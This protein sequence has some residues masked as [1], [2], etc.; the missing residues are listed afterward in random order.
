MRIH[1]FLICILPLAFAATQ[2]PA[3]VRAVP[4]RQQ[5]YLTAG[6]STYV[7]GVD[8]KKMVESLYWGPAL[9]QNTLL[10]TAKSARERAS[11]DNQ[12]NTTPLEYP[13]WGAGLDLEPALKV[14]S[15]N[16]DRTLVLQYDSANVGSDH[17]E[18]ILKDTAQP[19]R[20]HLHYQVFAEG[21]LARWSTIENI[22]NR[23]VHIEQAASA[24]FNLP[25]N[26]DYTLSQLTGMWGGEFQLQTEPLRFGAQQLESRR[27]STGHQANPWFSIGREGKTTETSGPVWFGELG[28]SGSWRVDV[29]RTSL[30]LVRITTGY[31][32]FDFGYTLAP[33]KSLDTPHVYAGYT[34]GGNGEAS[35]VLH[36]FQLAHILPKGPDAKPRPIIFNS[37]E[38]TEFH[39]SEAGQIALAE[40]AAKIGVERFVMDDGW[41]G[42]RKD[43]HAGLGDWYVNKE[44]FPNGL[45]PL[46]DRV[47]A[48]NMS[49][50]LWVEPEMVNP[51][52]DLYRKHPDW[53]MHFPDRQRTEQRNQLLLNLA[54]PEVKA[55]VFGWLDKLVTENDIAFLKWD[56]NRNW[57]EPGWGDVPQG[58][59][60]KQIYVA[61]VQNLYDIFDKLRA[62][63]PLLEI[64]SCSGGGGRVDLGILRYTDEVW[65]SDNTDAFDRL[66]IQDGFTRAYTPQAMVA[67]VTDVPNSLNR[68]SVPLEYRF[69]VAM[70][71]ALGIGNDLNKFTDA[72][73]ALATKLTTLY[74]DVRTTV[75]HGNLYRLQ[76]P[77][78][79]ATQVQYV[80]RD[81]AQSVVFAYLHSERLGLVQPRV[82][83]EGLDANSTYKLQPLDGSKFHGESTATGAQL[84]GSGLDLRL[85]GDFDSTAAVLTRVIP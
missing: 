53:A 82:P 18:L 21:V 54:K 73:M 52:S 57:S 83:L 72:D 48:L 85:T 17:L 4:E 69:L 29:E 28:W 1:R 65:P 60:Q 49:F 51:D 79:E 45:K 9:T 41:F 63:H 56:Y 33:G 76:T 44:K 3:Q 70:Q 42:Q 7:V 43:D 36:R 77:P 38:A 81:G 22:G 64:E 80:S 13:A 35:R 14:D 67:W 40:K 46:I 34:N 26:T 55:Y 68:R 12:M 15:A 20:V 58:S 74:K 25:A 61:Y 6:H 66:S 32:P 47:H 11:F 2:L 27:G 23:P 50:G 10:P 30:N 59:D 84:M 37:W 39:V 16:G 71:G 78:S 8:E 5:W 24:T 62:K 31:N 19:V 75:Q